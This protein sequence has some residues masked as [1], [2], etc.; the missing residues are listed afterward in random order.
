MNKIKN[1][2]DYIK[3]NPKGYWFRR[4][5]YGWGWTPARWQGW[6]VTGLFIGFVLWQAVCLDSLA[7]ELTRGELLSFFVKL[8]VAIVVFLAIANKKGEKP[9]WQWGVPDGE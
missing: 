6:L 4:K 1:Y 5:L 9:K 2:I 7:E 3:D 8:A